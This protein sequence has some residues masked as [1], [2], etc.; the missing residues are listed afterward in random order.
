[1]PLRL[2]KKQKPAHLALRAQIA[3]ANARAKE[4][5]ARAVQAQL[6]LAKLEA[7]RTLRPEQQRRVAAKIKN[8]SGAK[9]AAY[10]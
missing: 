6:N 3:S 2:R 10:T 7:P 8:F 1:M 9:F 5:D 4:A